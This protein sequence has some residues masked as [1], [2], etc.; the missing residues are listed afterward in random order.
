MSEPNPEEEEGQQRQRRFRIPSAAEMEQQQTTAAQRLADNPEQVAFDLST[1]TLQ[2]Q[3]KT[4]S[5]VPR[6][7][8]GSPNPTATL[9]AGSMGSPSGRGSGGQLV[10]VN[11][12]QRGNPLLGN[13]RNVRWAYSRNLVADFEVNRSIC[14]LYLSV[15]YH[16]LHPEYIGKRMEALGRGYGSRILLVLVD[17]DDNRAP[18]REIN[19]MALR[20]EMTLLLAWSLEEAGRYIETLKTLENRRPD[21]IRE[22]VEDSHV[23]RLTSSLT[24]I[25]S[26]NKTDVLTLASNFGSVAGVA[27][28][29]VE[30]LAMCPGIGEAKAQRIHRAFN[31]SFLLR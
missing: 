23:A 21:L 14:M 13:I 1:S 30:Q 6:P 22:R 25:R 18:L 26:V 8:T 31:E 2:P 27:A 19:C 20:G 11:E 4:A 24:G 15:K 17:T 9:P 28:A 12:L 7:A 16:R 10:Q 5:P 29:S 3:Q